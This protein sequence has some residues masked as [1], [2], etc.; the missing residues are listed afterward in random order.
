MRL[1]AESAKETELRLELILSGLPEPECGVAIHR[2]TGAWIGWFDLVWPRWRVVVEYDGD[3]HRT[4][5]QQYERDQRRAEALAEEGWTLV[6]IRASGLGSAAPTTV[7]RV[8]RALV[9]AGWRA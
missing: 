1:G 4:S 7:A 8:R 2:A 3:Q 9:A 5:R 6:R